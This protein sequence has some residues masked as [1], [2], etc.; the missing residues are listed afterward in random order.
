[1]I[2][3]NASIG[4]LR[5]SIEP[6]RAPPLCVPADDLSGVMMGNPPL[7]VFADEQVACGERATV[8]FFLAQHQGDIAVKEH[9]F[10]EHATR[11]ASGFDRIPAQLS[12]IVVRSF[13]AVPGWRHATGT[14]WA[15]SISI[16]ARSRAVK[17]R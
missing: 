8:E 11:G 7:A 9:L 10:I 16:A 1:M 6:P 12:M 13:S 3:R 17:A 14:L 15:Q 4:G 2:T 5:P